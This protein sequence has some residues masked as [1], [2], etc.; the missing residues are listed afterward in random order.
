MTQQQWNQP[1]EDDVQMPLGVGDGGGGGAE[2]G[3]EER[4]PRVNGST[5][6]LVGAFA[7]ALSLL[8]VFWVRGL[9]GGLLVG[10]MAFALVFYSTAYSL[11]NVPY[12]AMPG[13]MTDGYHERLR[14]MS[15][16]TAFVGS[17]GLATK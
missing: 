12:F 9:E 4:K 15:F 10:Y 7:S 1:S 14:I 5:F 8:L 2:L 3:G 6:V 13:E 16:R 11:F 17:A